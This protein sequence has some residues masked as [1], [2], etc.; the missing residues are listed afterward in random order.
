MLSMVS[1]DFMSTPFFILIIL[2]PSPEE[3]SIVGL[4]TALPMSLRQLNAC[5]E[6]ITSCQLFVK[7]FDVL[8]TNTLGFL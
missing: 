5:S 8:A 2:M 7:T 1:F 6:E 4:M 3:E